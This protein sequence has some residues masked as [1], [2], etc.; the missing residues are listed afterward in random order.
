MT[1]SQA[2][3]AALI[4]AGKV[5]LHIALSGAITAL[6]V[7]LSHNAALIALYPAINVAEAGILK[8]LNGVL[9]TLPTPPAA[10]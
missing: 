8:Y 5:L 9:G 4:T 10:S 7:Y 1:H 3:S 6:V 2:I